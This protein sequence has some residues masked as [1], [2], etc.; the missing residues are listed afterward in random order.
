MTSLHVWKSENK[1]RAFEQQRLAVEEQRA[2]LDRQIAEEKAIRRSLVLMDEAEVDAGDAVME[3]SN[4]ASSNS[5][6]R[7]EQPPAAKKTKTQV[8]AASE[9]KRLRD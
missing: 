5:A 4:S 1:I 2:A 7:G 6:S 9:L 3:A 8:A